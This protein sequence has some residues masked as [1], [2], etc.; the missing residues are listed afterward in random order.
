[1]SGDREWL[2]VAEEAESDP[3]LR[4]ALELVQAR[5]TAHRPDVARSGAQAA[6][7]AAELAKT[8]TKA[9][10]PVPK[11]V[12]PVTPGAQAAVSAAALAKPNAKA[13][14]PVPKEVETVTPVPPPTAEAYAIGTPRCII[15]VPGLG[16]MP[17]ASPKAKKKTIYD[18]TLAM[19]PDT[20]DPR[21]L[22]EGPCGVQH[23]AYYEEKNAWHIGRRCSRCDLRLQ[24]VPAKNAPAS[25]AKTYHADRVRAALEMAAMIDLV[26][27]EAKQIKALVKIAEAM[28]MVPGKIT[29]SKTEIELT[30]STGQP[31]V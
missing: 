15:E 17:K 8:N 14:T 26:E 20:T 9:P 28:R 6:D 25:S 1:M 27:P 2:D 29:L 16:T 19:G 31:P 30:L 18:E 10:K 12:E 23:A 7:S 3:Q 11:A 5:L 4:A 24:Y 21:Y 13:P 22:G